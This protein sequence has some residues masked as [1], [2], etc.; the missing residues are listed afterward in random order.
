VLQHFRRVADA[1]SVPVCLYNNPGRTALNMK[2][3]TVLRLA[4]HG[5]VCGV[6]ESSGDL[7]QVQHLLL[8]RP[9]GFAVMCGEDWMTL[10]ILAAGGDGLI[11]VVSNEAPAEMSRLVQATLAGRM[12]EA[13][14]LLYQLLPLMEATFI[15]TNPGPAKAALGA[16]GRISN[17]LR[18][19]LVPLS[20]H[21]RAPLL[22]ALKE[23]GVEPSWERSA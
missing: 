18:L 9:E 21:R 6:K 5:N 15:E 7:A 22:A 12:A 3:D 8:G 16:M 10:A 23:A 2:P 20:E 19:P 17:V 1:S 14:A 13:R 4:E 11:S